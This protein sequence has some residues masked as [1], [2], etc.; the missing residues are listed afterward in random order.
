MK[1]SAFPSLVYMRKQSVFDRVPFGAIGWVMC[2]HDVDIQHLG[3]KPQIFFDEVMPRIVRAPTVT[4]EQHP[5]CLRVLPLQIALPK[6]GQVVTNESRGVMAVSKAEVS[7]V[8]AHVI[9]AVRDDKALSG[10]FEVVVIHLAVHFV[11][12]LT[13]TVKIAQEFFLLRV[14]AQNRHSK[15]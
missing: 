13:S 2:H 9:N 3:Q 8:V 11:I 10:T 15:V 5:F 12:V 7:E 6:M 4:K 1:D 14:N